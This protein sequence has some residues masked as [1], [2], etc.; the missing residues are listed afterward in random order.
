MPEFEVRLS[1]VD[2][3]NFKIILIDAKS[4]EAA[5]PKA[6][7]LAKKYGAAFFELR[8]PLTQRWVRRD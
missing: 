7:A 1:S 4:E 3:K 6:A 8:R 5:L 2:E